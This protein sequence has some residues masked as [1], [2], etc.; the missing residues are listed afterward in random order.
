MRCFT[1][2]TLVNNAHSVYLLPYW[3]GIQGGN[4]LLALP[5]YISGASR[6]SVPSTEYSQTE[7]VHGTIAVY[8]QILARVR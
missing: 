5:K 8:E 1:S 2:L 6:F 7:A 4:A 3:C